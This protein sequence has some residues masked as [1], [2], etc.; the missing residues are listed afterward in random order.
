MKMK[1]AYIA[2]PIAGDVKGNI[3]KIIKIVRDIN[4]TKPDV[5]PFA[6][7]IADV[8]ALDDNKPEERTIGIRNCIKI[9]SSGIISEVWVYGPRISG[10]MKIELNLALKK[11]I[12]VWFMDPNTPFPVELEAFVYI[13]Y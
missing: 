7:Y 13:G 1:I 8:L 3:K 5:V 12:P 6:P 9:L 10:G 4:L 2:H 11:G